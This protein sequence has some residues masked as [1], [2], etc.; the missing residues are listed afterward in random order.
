[1][2]RLWI[3][4]VLGLIAALGFA[5]SDQG[6]DKPQSVSST[7]PIVS[8]SPTPTAAP[9]GSASL[10]P[11][12]TPS[13]THSD[14]EES[15]VV[16]VVSPIPSPAA[17]P[18]NWPTFAAAADGFSIRYPAGWNVDPTLRRVLSWAPDSS[19][20]YPPGG[21]LVEVS[22]TPV[23]A[24]GPRPSPT[25]ATSA[26]LGGE[27]GWRVVRK[28]PAPP[29]GTPAWSHGLSVVHG[30]L[31]YTLT[32]FFQQP[33]PDDSVFLQMAGTFAFTK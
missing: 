19:D 30:G 12:V 18:A 28:Y 7:T 6:D 22:I 1:M 21:V 2:R 16:P 9:A 27:A 10:G 29:A 33:N 15:V 17:V 20:S 32:G 3:L 23:G 24:D 26:S 4:P 31:T 25:G 5:C 13:P 8:A 11:T 14:A